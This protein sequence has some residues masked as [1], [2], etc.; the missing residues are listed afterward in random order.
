MDKSD[1]GV[2][3]AAQRKQRGLTQEQLG[4]LVGVSTARFLTRKVFCRCES[5]RSIGKSRSS[6]GSFRRCNPDKSK[7][8][9]KARF[10]SHEARLFCV[11]FIMHDYDGPLQRDGT[12]DLILAGS[13]PALR[14][15]AY[16]LRDPP[17]GR[18]CRA[19]AG[20]ALACTRACGPRSARIPPGPQSRSCAARG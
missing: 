15:S 19:R 20:C 9:P 8:R 10:V 6:C 13:A 1:M 16:I 12:A 14:T 18:A 5:T 2:R 7:K 3:I 4:R 17:A 11:E